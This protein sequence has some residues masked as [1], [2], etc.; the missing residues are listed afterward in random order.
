MP[1]AVNASALNLPINIDSPVDADYSDQTRQ[2]FTR[3]QRLNRP[4]EF[5][6]VFQYNRR[7]GD[8]YFTILGHNT[9]K[10]PARLGLAIAR[11]QVK[12]AVARN[13]LKRLI[14]ESFRRHQHDLQGWDIVVMLKQDA[15]KLTNQV[16]YDML[17][18]L[19]LALIKTGL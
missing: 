1:K 10:N 19:W 3:S 12:R 8:A 14:R 4:A 13:R 18:K 15:S 5:K 9:Q 16:I 17:A 11:K 2:R 7:L 6:R